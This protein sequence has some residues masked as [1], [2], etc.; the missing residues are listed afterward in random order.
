MIGAA[1]II[2]TIVASVLKF[3]TYDV[4]KWVIQKAFLYGLFTLVLPVVLFKLFSKILLWTMEYCQ[5]VITVSGGVPST[6]VELTQ[7]GAWMADCTRLP[8][9]ISIFLSALALKFTLQ[10]ISSKF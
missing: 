3:F 6:M 8:E 9:C 10:M 1:L 2:P 5:S 4:A 7:M